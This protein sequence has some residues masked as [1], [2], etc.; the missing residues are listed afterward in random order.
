[1][2][3]PYQWVTLHQ[4][5]LHA[6]QRRLPPLRHQI[7]QP[8]WVDTHNYGYTPMCTML[9]SKNEPILGVK[10][11]Y[12]FDLLGEKKDKT[13]SHFLKCQSIACSSLEILLKTWEEPNNSS[14]DGNGILS[15]YPAVRQL[16]RKDGGPGGQP[17]LT[18]ARRRVP[19]CS[20]SAS[21][22][23]A[24]HHILS[25]TMIGGGGAAGGI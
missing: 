2:L 7:K 24:T 5:P 16:I 10:S 23:Q 13:F 3:P 14:D 9:K 17:D 1:M 15:A 6:Y 25:Q 4:C 21:S 20:S 22:E 11:F 18:P 12:T 19:H 8:K